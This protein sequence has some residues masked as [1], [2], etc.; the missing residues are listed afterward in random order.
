LKEP[1]I[2]LVFLLSAAALSGCGKS[3]AP[4]HVAPAAEPRWEGTLQPAPELLVM[5]RPQALRRD[6][7]YGPLVGRAIELAREHTPLVAAT[8]ALDVME[9]AEEVIV[10]MRD[11]DSGGPG[12]LVLVVRGVGANVDP[13]NLPD[14]AGRPLWAPGSNGSAPGVRELLRVKGERAD[15]TEPRGR[16]NANEVAPGGTAAVDAS[17]FELPGRTWV[18]ATGRERARARDA[19]LRPRA[20]AG[21]PVGA[22]SAA[23]AF[24]QLKGS[25][26]VARVRAL[27][28]PGLLAP[29]GSKLDTV[30]VVLPP[31]G[32][33]EGG[34]IRAT[35]SYKDEH[36]VALAEATLRDAIAALFRAKPAEYVWLRTVTV[37]ASHCCVEVTTPLPR[38]LI[39]PPPKGVDA[40]EESARHIAHPG[41][42]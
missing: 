37:Q 14:E 1:G 29:L 13:A 19:F 3:A 31:S 27:R 23:L 41:S 38:G 24:V 28:P 9:D 2:G 8:G 6:A 16:P 33:G 32:D 7:V 22:P 10:G 35:L 21:D 17:L 18:M 12:D 25:A 5:V 20:V 39:G 15:G 40:D 4:S 11:S 30:T 34:A 36:A 42:E 26:L